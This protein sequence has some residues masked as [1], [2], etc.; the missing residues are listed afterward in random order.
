MLS[1]FAIHVQRYIEL[2]GV[3]D[4][5][6]GDQPGAEWFQGVCTFA[7]GPLR[8]SLQLKDSFRDVVAHT[9]ARD[10]AHGIFYRDICPRLAE[11]HG[12]FGFP[13][14]LRAA[15]GHHHRVVWPV[16]GAGR[17]QHEHGLLGRLESRF[18]GMLA[19]G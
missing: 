10:V 16:D 14:Q 19:I 1:D 17:G 18:G 11:H 6:G 3:A 2:V 7:F 15:L 12:E 13:I 8:A 4:F 9:K 5:I